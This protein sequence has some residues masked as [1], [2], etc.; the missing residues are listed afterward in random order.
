M[1]LGVDFYKEHSDWKIFKF[2]WRCVKYRLCSSVTLQYCIGYKVH[3]AQGHT[4]I[5]LE[6]RT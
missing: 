5:C 6:R 3:I 1:A 4:I 2:I